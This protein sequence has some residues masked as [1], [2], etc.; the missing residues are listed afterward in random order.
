MH[1]VAKFY[2]YFVCRAFEFCSYFVYSVGMENAI[3]RKIL[4]FLAKWRSSENHLPLIIRGARQ[5]GKTY[6]VRQFGKNYKS[7]VEINFVDSPEYKDIFLRGYSTD[8]VI[9][10]ISFHNPK[11]KFIPKETLI[12]FDELQ[13][14]PDCSTS[15]KFF[16]E[17]GRFDVICSG[18]MMG[19]NYRQISSNSVGYKLDYQMYSLDF[20]EYL[21][22]KGYG[23]SFTEDL[24]SHLKNLE[25]FS[26]EELNLL[27]DYF[28]EYAVIGGM[29][30]VVKRFLIDGNYSNILPLQSQLVRDYEEDITKYAD[31]LDKTKIKNIYR[32]IPVFLAHENKKFQITKVAKNARSR[33]YVGCA[34]WL[35]D[36]GVV[37][38]CFCL[39]NVCLP[40][41][42]NYDEAKY[43]IYYHDTGLLMAN[44]DEE[45][46]EDLRKNK[47]LGIFKGA[48]YENLV[49]QMLKTAGFDLYYY[50]KEN[51]QLEMDFF[52]RTTES[53]VPVEVKAKDGA[54]VSLNNLIKYPSYKDVR[55]GIKF[56]NKNIGFNGR[57]YTIPYFCAFLLKRFLR[58]DFVVA[59]NREKPDGLK[60]DE[61]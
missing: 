3:R 23:E 15:L 53:L 37:N 17:D 54:T 10:R 2:S 25:P 30:A 47:N 36:A 43:K 8:E 52:V 40:L 12:F 29:P 38:L 44:L 18:S 60:K 16:A 46:S 45:S 1:S 49:G 20:E 24:Y 6:S 58:E 59:T 14:Y 51:A 26:K 9:K 5:I 19:L 50:K 57:F 32:N 41:K 34:E 56:C 31:G 33:D 21:W 42:G 39:N 35:R 55:F 48:I 7:F 27:N 4:D 13:E 11:F 61:V 22:A 28:L